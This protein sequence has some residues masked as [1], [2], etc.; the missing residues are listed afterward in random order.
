MSA[1]AVF[2]LRAY[3]NAL[4][5]AHPD[6][7]LRVREVV[8]R[9]YELTALS[10]E[11]ERRGRTPVMWF[12]A[13]RDAAMPVVQNLFA[14]RRAFAFALGVAEERLIEVWSGLDAEPIPPV[15]RAG[16][17]ILD[18]IAEGAAVD[19]AALPIPKHFQEDGGAYITAGIVV[20]KHPR[21]GV[22]N[23]SFH[24]MRVNGRNRLGTSLHSRRHLWHYAREAE[25]M[26]LDRMPASVVI[27]CHPLVTFGAGIWKGSIEADEFAVAGS[28]MG[29][30]LE[31]VEGRT[32]PVEVPAEAEIV[33]EGHL[34]LGE[35]EPE[36]PF[37]EFTGY[38]SER[39]TNHRFE[40]SAILMREGAVYHNIVGGISAEHTLLLAVPHEA[41]QLAGLRGSNPNVTEV[42]YPKSGACRLHAYVAVRDAAPGQARNIALAALGEDLSL[43]LVV[44]V[45]DD[46]DVRD[47]SA[48]LWAMATR[49]QADADVD[50]IRNAMGA[51]LDPSNDAGR[52]AKMIVDATRPRDPYARRHSLPE[53]AERRAR[54]MVDGL[55][56]A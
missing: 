5:S 21:T 25:A 37:G 52:T 39:S 19:L 49:M 9:D 41:R 26:G 40:V 17:P 45:D 27:G 22:R 11:L 28:F 43:K 36:G 51:I 42:A 50:V 6:E 30:P 2:S 3:I 16:G 44:V 53:A 48:V 4:E 14:S 15:V 38:A 1:D 34:V 23:A 8:D 33:L 35:E 20:A 10:F 24:R 55:G 31:L 54:E 47:D 29:W 46:V 13:V 56:K 18:H 32:V 7:V 12:D